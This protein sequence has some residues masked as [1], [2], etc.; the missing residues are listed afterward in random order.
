ML[1][2]TGLLLTLAAPAPAAETGEST[3]LLLVRHAEKEATA[4]NPN[5]TPRGAARAEALA[6]VAADYGVAG[7]YSTDFCRTALT[8]LPAARRAGI[9]I[10]VQATGHASAGLDDCRP[11]IDHP[12]LFLDPAIGSA[13]DL[14]SW[15]LDQH[16]GRSVLIVGHSNTVPRLLARIGAGIFEPVE[17]AEDQYDRMFVV[18]VEPGRR[19]TMMETSYGESAAT[20]ESS[21]IERAIEFHGGDAYRNRQIRMTLSSKSGRFELDVVRDGGRYDD[22]V[23][24]S[25][26]GS[27]RVT[28]IT[29]DTVE[30]T[31]GGEAQPLDDDQRRRLRSFVDARV[32][33]PLLP[34]GL[35]APEVRSTDQGV[36][37]WSG[38]SLQRVKV[39]FEP[40]SSD[41]ADSEYAFW[42]EPESG[43]LRQY[44]Y[45]F[46]GG[47][48]FRRLYNYRRV[49]G[50]LFFDADNLG[51]DGDGPFTVDQVTPA[52][53]AA[54]CGESSGDC[55]RPISR[56]ELSDIEVAPLR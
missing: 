22:R 36:E 42:F 17:I 26:D 52:M 9:P 18:R 45:T 4:G 19:T 28:R 31:V 3:V 32:Y 33:F 37:S 40:G 1:A 21:I 29:N 24:D 53:A 25:V 14:L 51:I 39:T 55:L 12:I 8:A 38:R 54:E 43:R 41:G 30:R 10:A 23:I 47:L 44:A 20:T 7:I 16:A 48:R 6:Q 50:I 2:V 5:L 49:G 13:A 56:V 46:D 35:A 15:V 34:Y 11:P 27:R